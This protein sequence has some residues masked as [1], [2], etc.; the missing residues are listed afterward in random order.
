VLLGGFRERP[1]SPHH[2][3]RAKGTFLA[4]SIVPNARH[5]HKGSDGTDRGG[6]GTSDMNWGLLALFAVILAAVI[7]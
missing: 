2:G 4:P 1:R 6:K 7:A 5:R 3:I